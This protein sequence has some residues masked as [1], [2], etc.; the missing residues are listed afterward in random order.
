MI[1]T[2]PWETIE[3]ICYENDISREVNNING[4]ITLKKRV[5]DEL[6]KATFDDIT[7]SD[8]IEFIDK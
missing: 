1:Q 3:N 5:N 4:Y 8:V 6:I 7:I 2:M